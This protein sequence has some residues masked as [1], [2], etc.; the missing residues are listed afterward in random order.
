MKILTFTLLS[1][2]VLFGETPP[3]ANQPPAAPAPKPTVMKID[4]ELVQ[5]MESLN[6]DVV[7]LNLKICSTAKI[8]YKV[9]H[10]DWQSATVSEVQTV[11]EPPAAAAV[12]AKKK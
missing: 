7:I 4:P 12:P 3:A 5:Q 10:I 11:Q 1:C 9:C 6:K 2:S 8:S